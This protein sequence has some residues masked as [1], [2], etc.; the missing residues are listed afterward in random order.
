MFKRVGKTKLILSV[1][2]FAIFMAGLS[3]QVNAENMRDASENDPNFI[4]A[5]KVLIPADVYQIEK[6]FKDSMAVSE[7]VNRSAVKLSRTVHEISLEPG[8]ALPEIVI[9]PGYVTGI[10]FIDSAGNPWPVTSQTSG[11][12]AWF[13]LAKPEGLEPG[14]L[15]VLTSLSPKAHSNLL[16]TLKGLNT[17]I[18]VS[19]VTSDLSPKAPIDGVPTFRLPGLSPLAE[20]FKMSRELPPATDRLL[21]SVLNNIK[22]SGSTR[23]KTDNS[24]ISVWRV[25]SALYVR[26]PY[27]LKWPGLIDYTSS[28][29]V[30]VYKAPVSSRLIFEDKEFGRFNVKVDI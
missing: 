25:G 14:N 1:L 9:T 13:S 18:S 19:V 17:A 3:T 28:G 15:L 24:N 11:R 16:I 23:L 7:V 26:G 10:Q 30:F 21:M 29:S 22:P 12:E 20:P 5:Q 2:P 8:K 27:R 6:H 4:A